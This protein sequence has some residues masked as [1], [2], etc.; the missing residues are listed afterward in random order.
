M[1][2]GP[3]AFDPGH[4][5][6]ECLARSGL[7]R[8]RRH[9]RVIQEEDPGALVAAGFTEFGADAREQTVTVPLP[10]DKLVD[11]PDRLQQGVES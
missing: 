11:I 3:A 1:V 2:I 4:A 5:G 9:A 8:C 7:G 6:L 10:G